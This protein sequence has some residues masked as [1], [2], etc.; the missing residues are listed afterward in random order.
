MQLTMSTTTQAA[1]KSSSGESS[2]A[3]AKVKQ[4]RIL[5]SR[6]RSIKIKDYYLDKLVYYSDCSTSRC[7]SFIVKETVTHGNQMLRS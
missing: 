4:A 3:N 7:T 1:R 2:C 5:N 6:T